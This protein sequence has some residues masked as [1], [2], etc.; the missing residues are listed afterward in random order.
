MS[1]LSACI[2]PASAATFCAF[3]LPGTSTWIEP[4]DDVFAV[5]SIRNELDSTV[6][7]FCDLSIYGVTFRVEYAPERGR[8]PDWFHVTVPPGFRADPPS[9]L[10]DDET[11][12]E[13]LIILD[14]G[15]SS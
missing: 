2:I 6:R 9:I 14:E 3:G 5:V 7:N 11:G 1:C 10:L 4:G 15:E 8:L 12:G 13:V